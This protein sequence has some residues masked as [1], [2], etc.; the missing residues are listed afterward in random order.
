M[1]LLC[2]CDIWPISLYSLLSWGN[3][4]REVLCVKVWHFVSSCDARVLCLMVLRP[5]RNKF[6]FKNWRF[7][8]HLLASFF[9]HWPELQTPESGVRQGGTLVRS[10]F[11][12]FWGKAKLLSQGSGSILA[13]PLC[14]PELLSVAFC[15]CFW[16]SL[17]LGLERALQ[18]LISSEKTSSSHY[19]GNFGVG[20][21]LFSFGFYDLY[22]IFTACFF[23]RRVFRCLPL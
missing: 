14:C 9:L 6:A 19:L 1:A 17:L 7:Q 15:P 18:Y 12:A 16:S 23:R 20:E 5:Q 8:K 22:F 11:H 10:L 21:W 4:L 13:L 3:N 2:S